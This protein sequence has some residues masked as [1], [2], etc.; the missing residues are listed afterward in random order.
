MAHKI[1]TKSGGNWKRIKK[2]LEKKDNTWKRL[3]KGWEKRNNT[4]KLFFAGGFPEGI[5][6]PFYSSGSVPDGWQEFTAPYGRLII[7]ADSNYPS[8]SR[9]GSRT[10][11]HT[12]VVAT[13]GSHGG[14]AYP[15]HAKWISDGDCA[16]CVR[17]DGDSH[18]GYV[19][20]GHRHSNFTG[21]VQTE[22]INTELRLVQLTDDGADLPARVG[23]L[24]NINMAGQ[25]NMPASLTEL[26]AQSG[27]N[28]YYM[29]AGSSPGHTDGKRVWLS[30]PFET[31]YA[32]SHHHG[33]VSRTLKTGTEYEYA[34]FA[35]NHKHTGYI[36]ASTDSYTH[37]YLSVWYS[38]SDV[39]EA[40]P[41]M[42]GMWQGS[43]PPEGWVLCN[44]A[45][46]TV[47]GVT[48]TT[49]DLR[50]RFVRFADSG[51]RNITGGAMNI[52]LATYTDTNG[53]HDHRPPSNNAGEDWVGND[54]LRIK[55]YY[56]V[57]H[58]H[59]STYTWKVLT[60]EYYSLTFIMK[61]PE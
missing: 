24:S 55:H 21:T 14:E 8:G 1:Y 54:E 26:S 6:L 52:G 49:P 45:S 16:Y 40:S 34:V 41:Y 3:K 23:V 53:G 56:T 57:G 10:I 4:W 36:K 43:V 25:P 42:I 35:G 61:L 11:T 12:G 9:G 5:I 37:R 50:N 13:A 58:Y 15:W 47:D 33:G 29:S 18:E 31:S 22:P 39:I 30:P 48:V 2:G 32:G 60:P 44:G 28:D 59:A 7:G 27:F 46:H 51:T 38:A 17:Y 20:G 19:T